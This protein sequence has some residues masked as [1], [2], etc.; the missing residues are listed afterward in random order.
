MQGPYGFFT[1]PKDENQEIVF[2]NSIEISNI[3]LSGSLSDVLFKR[4]SGETDNYGSIIISEKGNPLSLKTITI[5]Q[6]GTVK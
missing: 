6:S 4:L 3:V 2:G 5:Q 1:L